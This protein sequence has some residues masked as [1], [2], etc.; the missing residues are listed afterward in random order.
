[1]RNENSAGQ[2]EQQASGCCRLVEWRCCAHKALGGTKRIGCRRPSAIVCDLSTRVTP[3]RVIDAQG[4]TITETTPPI[5]VEDCRDGSQAIVF[6]DGWLALV[7]EAVLR[8][9][10][11]SYRHRL[12]WVDQSGL[13]RRISRTFYFQQTG[14]EVRW[15]LDVAR[16]Q[17]T[18]R[19]IRRRRQRSMDRDD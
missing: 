4:R 12:V 13:L 1:M 5:A 9:G 3:H 18:C 16:R 17:T 2:C 19:V 8:E 11:R 7:H 14:A 10:R 15:W 6:A